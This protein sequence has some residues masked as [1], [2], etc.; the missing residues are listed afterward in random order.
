[1]G[2]PSRPANVLLD[3][4]GRLLGADGKPVPL[5]VPLI[6]QERKLLIREITDKIKPIISQTCATLTGMYLEPVK[7]AMRKMEAD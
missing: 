4:K 3:R 1:L 5:V 6:P 7:K 2:D